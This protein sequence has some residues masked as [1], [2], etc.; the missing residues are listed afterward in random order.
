MMALEVGVKL[1]KL[2]L[3]AGIEL[4]EAKRLRRLA[5]TAVDGG[6]LGYSL[7]TARKSSSQET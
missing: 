5:A 4:D 3:P 7:L 1:G 2:E 6:Q